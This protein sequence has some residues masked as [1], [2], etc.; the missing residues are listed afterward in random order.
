MRGKKEGIQVLVPKQYIFQNYPVEE[1]HIHR[2]N[3]KI[4]LK[5][6]RYGLR[7]PACKMGLYAFVLQQYESC[8]RDSEQSQ[9]D[10]GGDFK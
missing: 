1:Y 6:L 7:Q 3:G 2:F 9:Q 4:S 5:V 8:R 10:D